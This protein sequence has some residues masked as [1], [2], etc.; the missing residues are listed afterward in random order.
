MFMS[1]QDREPVVVYIK[2]VH[3][4]QLSVLGKALQQ[5][6]HNKQGIVQ[7]SCPFPYRGLV[8]VNIKHVHQARQ[9]GLCAVFFMRRTCGDGAAMCNL[10][11]FA[12]RG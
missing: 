2:D 8:A 10:F 4:Q 1:Q 3:D 5:K 11:W 6:R 7:S 9:Q 12:L